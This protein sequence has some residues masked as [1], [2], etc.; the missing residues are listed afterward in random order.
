M[1][2]P[3]KF[4]PI[5][6]DYLWG[7]R[8]LLKLDKPL[9]KENIAESWEISTHDAGESIIANGKFNHV[10]LKDLIDL[11]PNEVLGSNVTCSEKR[12]FPLLIKFIDA[13][14][15]LSV[16]VHPDDYYAN[17]FEDGQCGKNEM[18]YVLDAKDN[19]KLV[20]GLKKG[21]TKEI[22]KDSIKNNEVSKCLNYVDVKPGDIINIPAGTVH[23]IGDGILIC[24]IQ[25]SSNLTYRIY[26][27]DRKDKCGR[28]RPL[29]VDKALEVINFNERNVKSKYKGVKCIINSTCYKTYIA[30]TKK[31]SVEIYK[32]KGQTSMDTKFQS[33]HSYTCIGGNGQ[34]VYGDG[35][36]QFGIGE[37]ILVPSAL[38][39]Y[40]IEGV[41]EAIRCSIFSKTQIK[42]EINQLKYKGISVEE[43]INY[44]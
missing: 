4:K 12:G 39:K 11:Y 41:F 18:W 20:C 13:N 17:K 44:Y 30:L 33:F 27:Y 5:F 34:I 6:K 29:H 24:E 28:K 2:Y 16:Q 10:L 26:D 31:F 42:N 37:T 25:Q 36:E 35:F 40:H 21:I 32:I 19:S 1:F 15:S 3:L 43:I 7:G 8:N 14:D 23:A 22:F 38:G 9:P